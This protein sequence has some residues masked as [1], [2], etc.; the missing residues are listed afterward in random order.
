MHFM[1]QK[2]VA[3][4]LIA[5]PNSKNYGRLSIIAQ[6]FY[7]ITPLLE[8]SPKS[9]TPIPK[10]YS[11]FLKFSPKQKLK[12]EILNINILNDILKEAFGQRRKLLSNSLKKFFSFKSLN[13]LFIDCNIRAENVSTKDFYKLALLYEKEKNKNTI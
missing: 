10:V 4:R 11:M 3:N 2:E 6:Y 5:E 8:V 1:F 13:K 12:K 7:K 9:F